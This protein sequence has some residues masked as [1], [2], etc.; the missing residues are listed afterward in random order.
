MLIKTR[1]EY[2]CYLW[3]FKLK[4]RISAKFPDKY[5]CLFKLPSRRKLHTS[6]ICPPDYVSLLCEKE[7]IKLEKL[8]LQTNS[9]LEVCNKMRQAYEVELFCGLIRIDYLIC[10]RWKNTNNAC[11]CSLLKSGKSLG[12][13]LR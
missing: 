9:V 13:L 10:Y 5:L 11:S 4:T 7:N 12:L 6:W 2:N 8:L 1:H 3:A